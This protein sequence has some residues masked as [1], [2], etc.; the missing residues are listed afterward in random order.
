M[1]FMRV[2]VTFVEWKAIANCYVFHDF[3]DEEQVEEHFNTDRTEEVKSNEM[4][5]L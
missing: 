3:T 1:L 4:R 2:V 5:A